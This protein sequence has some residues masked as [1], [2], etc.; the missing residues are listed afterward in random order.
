MDL[1][2][3][4]EFFGGS[5]FAE[6][7]RGNF[8]DIKNR[9]Q[10][11]QEESDSQSDRQADICAKCLLLKGIFALLRGAHREATGY[12]T[13]TSGLSTRWRARLL[14]YYSLLV[15]WSR[16]PPHLRF[17]TE[18]GGFAGVLLGLRMEFEKNT[19]SL[20]E[21]INELSSSGSHVDSH[22]INVNRVI[23]MIAVQMR[24][25][26]QTSHPCFPQAYRIESTAGQDQ[27][28]A[29]LQSHVSQATEFGYAKLSRYLRRVQLEFIMATCSSDVDEA[30]SNLTEDYTAAQDWEGLA[31]I[32]VLNADRMLSPPFSNP[33]SLN[34]IAV[35]GHGAT[36]ANSQWSVVEAS[37]WLNDNSEAQLQY[38]KALDLFRMSGSR[39]GCAA[40]ILRQACVQ[41][42]A[43]LRQTPLSSI[44]RR[45]IE[46]AQKKLEEAGVL[47][48]MD[49]HHQLLVMAHRVIL[50]ICS[51]ETRDVVRYSQEIGSI[52]LQHGSLMTA[53]YAGLLMM[54]YGQRLWNDQAD[55]HA[56]FLSYECAHAC[57]L[58][59]QDQYLAFTALM[60]QLE[61]SA[62]IS[63]HTKA[64]VLAD[65]TVS[66]FR[67]LLKELNDVEPYSV[68]QNI[69][70]IIPGMIMTVGSAVS[71]AYYHA[72]DL[73]ALVQW[74][75]DIIALDATFSLV[76]DPEMANKSLFLDQHGWKDH[77]FSSMNVQLQNQRRR[78]HE[79]YLTNI[80]AQ[81]ALQQYDIVAAETL[82]QEFLD[83]LI[84]DP[85]DV[86]FRQGTRESFGI[87]VCYALGL[88]DR[89]RQLL[90]EVPSSSLVEGLVSKP[91]AGDYN[92]SCHMSR[93]FL[94]DSTLAEQALIVCIMAQDWEK[95]RMVL[96]KAQ[97][98]SQSFLDP[99]GMDREGDMWHRFLYAGLIAEHVGTEHE[100]MKLLLESKNILERRRQRTDGEDTRMAAFFTRDA[101]EVFHSLARVA[102][103]IYDSST[104]RTHDNSIGSTITPSYYE[105]DGESWIEQSFIFVEAGK[106]RTLLDSLVQSRS[107]P[108]HSTRN[109]SQLFKKRLRL[110]LLAIPVEHRRSR[111]V[112]ELQ[113]LEAELQNDEREADALSEAAL[114]SVNTPMNLS[115]QIPG[116]CVVVEFAF[117]YHGLLLFCFN[118]EG[119][120][121][122][123][124]SDYTFIQARRTVFKYLTEVTK[125]PDS[126]KDK[127]MR[128]ET[129]QGL[130]EE[131]SD[132]LV[133][134][135]AHYIQDK[136]HVVF[137]PSQP[138]LAFPFPAL[139]FRGEPLF[140]SKAVSQAPSLSALS[141]LA[142]RDHKG[143]PPKISALA[144]PGSVRSNNPEPPLKMAG[145]EAFTIAS[146]FGQ[147]PHNVQNM[148]SRDFLQL[149][150]DSDIFHVGTHGNV[151]PRSPWQSSISL[152]AP[153]RVV[154]VTQL[155]SCARL[156]V[157]SACV[158]GLGKATAGNDVTG[159]S[160]M[161]LSAGALVY[162]G[163]LWRVD[164]VSTMLLMILFYRSLH[165]SSGGLSVAERWRR[166][167]CSLYGMKR[168]EVQEL[169][170]GILVELEEWKKEGWV[171][172][173]FVSK[174]MV[175][176]RNK[177][178]HLEIDTKDPFTWAPFVIIGNGGLSLGA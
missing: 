29:L 10:A 30:V 134:P 27:W 62:T 49:V 171:V 126:P 115:N 26:G 81:N 64:R 140:L 23:A 15:S 149:L 73:A 6:E 44:R 85:P 169:I 120:Q 4:Y 177:K 164:D 116:D 173:N 72:N 158:S 152:S 151:D 22:E 145:I 123:K 52:A 75:E 135:A 66:S 1:N 99:N 168:G 105:L 59:M 95:G 94:W 53:Q 108:S 100:A 119:I 33:L 156:V 12:L 7:Y 54:K 37:M 32:H 46:E 58:A 142:A 157:F 63:H 137:I 68:G 19:L 34:L 42:A 74:Y 86:I 36:L 146:S 118:S 144:K 153:F 79:Y 56:A 131:L 138:A 47:F 89:A 172:E 103:R 127:K 67:P 155:T 111:E 18:A 112:T 143:W 88:F 163:S 114:S 102:L 69:H 11:L 130:T 165:E 24:L 147:Q 48:E 20:M 175:H 93:T 84:P 28:Q 174:G 91:T 65:R 82:W 2:E 124:V 35:D 3:I 154:D 13:S 160:H 96:D 83:K 51:G 133:L 139:L 55:S 109:V 31:S 141:K 136:A 21:T 60:P 162:V 16:Y 40:V 98:F 8:A 113:S 92:W 38:Q 5:I 104:G 87:Y 106:A 170:E 43:A 148:S 159:F 71:R 176:L 61:L 150:R 122:A 167:Q 39:R 128:S 78:T 121:Y 14:S 45:L 76:N 9:L 101:G 125:Q 161:M 25:N 57:F 166:A 97:R 41:H 178:K 110:D 80:K 129:L 17:R 90:D 50:N 107:D 77:S 70:L 117:S 132:Q